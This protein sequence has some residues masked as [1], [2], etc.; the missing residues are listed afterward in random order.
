MRFTARIE[1]SSQIVRLPRSAEIIRDRRRFEKSR[2]R[3]SARSQKNAPIPRCTCT[4]KNRCIPARRR[5]FAGRCNIR[6][7]WPRERDR[8]RG[9]W[10]RRLDEGSGYAKE[11]RRGTV[12]GRS[13]GER[14]STMTLR[15]GTSRCARRIIPVADL[16]KIWPRADT[17]HCANEN[18]SISRTALDDSKR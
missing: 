2:T 4:V 8:R 16:H 13:G 18:N 15:C 1:R 10:K 3:I 11:Q 14:E 5:R 7:T 12:I 9:P 17:F 6:R